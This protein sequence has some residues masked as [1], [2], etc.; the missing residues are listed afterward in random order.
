MTTFW[1]ASLRTR[2]FNFEAFGGSREEADRA[3]G[4]GIREHCRQYRT[5]EMEFRELYR[6]EIREVKCGTAYRDREPIP[7]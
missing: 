6:P 4:A 1:I 5:P 3:M 7:V 2:H